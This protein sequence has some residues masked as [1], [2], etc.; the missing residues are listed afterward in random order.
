VVKKN[1]LYNYGGIMKKI[2]WIIG[3]V[4]VVLIIACII[5]SKMQGI[6]V[7]AKKITKGTVSEYIEERAVTTLSHLYK[8][9]M[10]LSGRIK[11]ILLTP[12]TSVKKGQIIA[13]MDEA[14]LKSTIAE[15]KAKVNAIK[16]QIAINQ[17]HALETT[18][19]NEAEKWIKTMENLVKVSEK[20]VEAS[21]QVHRFAATYEKTLTESGQAISR[22][23]DT[24]AK[25]ET[26]VKNVE[27][28]TANIMQ[29]VYTIINSIF[30]LAPVY[31]NEYIHVKS[32]NDEV[33]RSQ[34]AEVETVL[35]KTQRN[36][37]R[38]K[39][40]SPIDGIILNRY[41]K[42]ERFLGIGTPILDIGDLNDLQI[43][44]NILSDEAINISPGDSVNIFGAA[45]GDI[46]INGKVL[47]VDPK[48]F[49]KLSSL[50]VE[51]QRVHV[52]IAF[53]K[54]SL[55]VLKKAQKKLGD[56]FRLQVKVYTA[57]KDNVV[58]VPRTA[59]FKSNDGKWK[60]FII[61][62]NKAR[63]QDIT[64]GL[65]NDNE[66]EAIKGLKAGDEVILAPSNTM[67][68]GTRVSY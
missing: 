61:K 64:I 46:P 49:T 48:G 9:T 6:S 55:E 14:N 5:Y 8:I 31:I 47:R 62:D 28:E 40:I 57:T 11:P 43:T 26:A 22:I 33:L 63:V 30:K 44:S 60:V 51:Q 3:I 24:K 36:L 1:N 32:L 37:K 15:A 18:A 58:K 56:G 35:Q 42:N 21:E 59:L 29:N 20:K 23:R 34:L 53:N 19:L 27:L 12:G 54:G 65:I 38:S 45:I 7:R 25:M 4:V 41:V 17:Y 66:A 67:A 2:K 10:P 50:G 52:K 16:G 39:I 13:Q 68:D